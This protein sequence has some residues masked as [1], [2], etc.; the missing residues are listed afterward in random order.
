VNIVRLKNLKI[1]DSLVPCTIK[2][3][4]NTLGNDY[5]NDKYEYIN[6]DSRFYNYNHSVTIFTKINL[7]IPVPVYGV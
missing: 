7:D 3:Y 2:V 1:E 5:N 6:V 4:R